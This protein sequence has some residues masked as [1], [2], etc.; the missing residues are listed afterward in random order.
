MKNILLPSFEKT[1]EIFLPPKVNLLTL[2]L[3][4]FI[5]KRLKLLLLKALFVSLELI[6][7][8]LLCAVNEI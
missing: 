2:L 6:T 5:S 4:L 1:G 7:I 3:F 8:A